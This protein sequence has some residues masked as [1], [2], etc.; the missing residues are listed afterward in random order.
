[1]CKSRLLQFIFVCSF[2]GLVIFMFAG[3][4]GSKSEQAKTPSQDILFASGSPGGSWAQIATML[5]D[6]CKENIEN[7]NYTIMPGGGAT[8][9][10]LVARGE[11]NVGMTFI[12]NLTDI[13]LGRGRYEQEFTG[14]A[15]NLRGMTRLGVTSWGHLVISADLARQ[16]NI[17]TAKDIFEQKV[18]VK[19]NV[20]QVGQ[21]DEEFAG[22]ILGAYGVTYKDVESWGGQVTYSPNSDAID[23]FV[24]GNQCNLLVFVERI[25]LAEIV[26]LFS[27]RNCVYVPIDADIITSMAAEYNY[28]RGIVP[29]GRYRGVEGGIET[30]YIE[31]VVFCSDQMPEDVIYKMTKTILENKETWIKTN[32]AF[33]AFDPVNAGK[34]IPVPL[35]PG[36][37]K[38]YKELGYL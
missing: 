7:F 14:G 17:K 37:E 5:S 15:K 12:T 11:A 38:A 33:E 4:S 21:G 31:Q 28:M 35:H 16:Y 13:A 2:A 20:G 24:N 29:G 23:R 26:E 34:N 3:C 32:A 30:L 19:M 27:A 36:A 6:K 22:R 10:I 9:V 25:G 8:N 1:M 18:P